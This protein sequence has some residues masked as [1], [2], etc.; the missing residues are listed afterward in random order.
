M[1]AKSG[2]FAAT[3]TW[4]GEGLSVRRPSFRRVAF[5]P[6]IHVRSP[7][8]HDSVGQ[9]TLAQ[10]QRGTGEARSDAIPC[11]LWEWN[12]PPA[13]SVM[14][15]PDF[16]DVC[17]ARLRA[18]ILSQ[19]LQF[20]QLA[21]H[22][23]EIFFEPFLQDQGLPLSN[24]DCIELGIKQLELHS[25]S[26]PDEVQ[27]N[28][29]EEG[30]STACVQPA[31]MSLYGPRSAKPDPHEV[32][33]LP[34]P[35][36]SSGSENDQRDRPPPLRHLPAWVRQ[37]WNILQ[38]EGATE[39]L[40]E[41]PVVYFGSYYISHET[42]IRQ[43]ENPPVRLNRNYHEWLREIPQVWQDQF[44]RRSGY[45]LFLVQPDPPI[46][47]T[48]GTVGI[49]LIVQH[50]VRGQ[51]AVVTTAMYEDIDGPRIQKIAHSLPLRVPPRDL[52]RHAGALEYCD[53]VRRHGFDPCH[54]RAGHH[55]FLPD[56][57]IRVHDGLGL[58]IRIPM[59]I[60]DAERE[61]LMV[62]RLRAA[63]RASDQFHFPD[64]EEE[65]DQASLMA[66]RP[67]MRA[68]THERTSS[69][70]SASSTN[71]SSTSM[72]DQEPEDLPLQHTVLFTLDGR[73]IA[74]LI[75]LMDEAESTLRISAALEIPQQ[76]IMD[77]HHV[78]HPPND[79]AQL[80]LHGMVVQRQHEH[81]QHACMRLVL[82]DIDIFMDQEIL[83]FA[84]RRTAQWLPCRVTRLTLLRLLC[85]Q[86]VCEQ[87]EQNDRQCHVRHNHVGCLDSDQHTIDIDDGDSLHIF[88]GDDLQRRSCDSEAE[89]EMQL[90]QVSAQRTNKVHQSQVCSTDFDRR[91]SGVRPRRQRHRLVRNEQADDFQHLRPLWNRPDRRTRGPQNEET[92]T[93]ETWFL[94]PLDFPRCSSSRL[95]A[96]PAD[97]T[98]W[99]QRLAQVWRDRVRGHWPLRLI[100][101]EPIPRGD[102]HGGHLL[103]L[104]HEHTGEV[105]VLMS[106]YQGI[107]TTAPFDR[108][109]QI[110]PLEMTFHRYLWFQDQEHHC[111]Q[112]RI[113]CDGFHGE[114]HISPHHA[115]RGTNG[116]HLE[117]YIHDFHNDAMAMMQQ[118][119]RTSKPTQAALDIA[120]ESAE[121]TAFQFNIDAP[122]F[123]PI[124][125]LVAMET[126]VRSC[127]FA[128]WFV[129]HSWQWPHGREFR[130]VRLYED[131]TQW[132]LLILQT[133]NEF[134]TPGA[135]V[136]FTLVAPRPDEPVTVA[137]HIIVI[138]RPR[139]EWV[140]SL[141]T[142]QDWTQQGMPKWQRAVTSSEH[143]LLEDVLPVLSL[144]DQCLGTAPTYQCL[145]WYQ[146]LELRPEHPIMGRSGYHITIQLRPGRPYTDSETHGSP[147]LLQLSKLLHLK[148]DPGERLTTGSVAHD[149]WPPQDPLSFPAVG[150]ICPDDCEPVAQTVIV[151]VH[152]ALCTRSVWLVPDHLE[153]PLSFST[154]DAKAELLA[155]GTRGDVFHCGV[156]DAIFVDILDDPSCSGIQYVY[157]STKADDT[158]GIYCHH[159]AVVLT[160][161]EHM[162]FLHQQ[163]RNKSVVLRTEAWRPDLHCVHCVR[164]DDVQPSHEQRQPLCRVRTP[165]PTRQ[166]TN[167][168]ARPCFQPVR[169]LPETADCLL[170]CDTHLLAG[171]LSSTQS[172]LWTDYSILELP[173]FIVE[174]L[175][176]CTAVERTD[177][178]VIFTDGSSQARHRHRPPEWVADFDIS[179][180]WAFLVLAEQYGHSNEE[181]SKLQFLGFQC[182][183]V[184][185]ETEA[186]H[187][188][189]TQRIG[190]DAAETEALF[191]AGL[192]RLAENNNIATVFVSDSRLV[193]DQAA[194]R[195]GSRL[196]DAPFRHLRE[197]FKP[198]KP[199]C[200][201]TNYELNMF[202]VMQEIP[203]MNSLTS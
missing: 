107:A 2:S 5:W 32:P 104:Q 87:A 182:H 109:A 175:D 183:Q 188:I 137:G 25:P 21:P 140:T 101:I 200:L 100:P 176:Q 116:Q 20:D 30:I 8:G 173:A 189:G 118:S 80:G 190:S 89:E 191:W 94:S 81:R 150:E 99:T 16:I 22:L 131:F 166:S 133:W 91:A 13:H 78:A 114:R 144:A 180:S 130:I 124:Q 119:I 15:E 92:I 97:L 126:E 147:V 90:M 17:T 136:E 128:I 74:V 158:C 167:S 67:Q 43:E 60:D 40:E 11:G 203:L 73:S 185:Y 132:E 138:Q 58:I 134:R 149:Q 115:W 151:K 164:F 48:Q 47:V 34:D 3:S 113:Q 45:E 49:L 18:H 98:I 44:D 12:Q 141:I 37:L 27:V 54:I 154:E 179:D 85:L 184:L 23:D 122:A 14:F 93:L 84:F 172:I 66:R 135:E 72:E 139:E 194:G 77:F 159:S 10:L 181:P 125:Q 146:Q 50:P 129:D 71:S 169:A 79:F 162:K 187:H 51:A 35:P 201:V 26:I 199:A 62:E 29:T 168:T 31:H 7:K 163:G 127:Q 33:N 95:V 36:S 143:I 152:T 120:D 63:A 178:Y 198:W 157:C 193:G 195:V 52:L 96:L 82:I 56:E 174:T 111:Y 170:H 70:S 142:I 59:M 1:E 19:S 88:I 165:W 39:L 108:F 160:E 41:G 196:Q 177:R 55:I 197:V 69:S 148:Q 38:D 83:P 61:R 75:P 103:V 161:L 145:A 64:D 6:T 9:C 53:E 4:R 46:L 156:H 117:L 110:V 121:C 65:A 42:C 102:R 202:A 106:Q 86:A 153:L 28:E 123:V 76:D 155:W 68:P 192:W 112:E 171:F 24:E 186:P 57:P 105:G